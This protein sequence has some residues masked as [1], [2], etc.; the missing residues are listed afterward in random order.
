MTI[1]RR[2]A[3]SA[4]VAVL[5]LVASSCFYGAALQHQADH[6]DTRPWWC[7]ST[8]TGGHHVDP[9]YDGQEKGML[10]W[11]DCLALSAHQA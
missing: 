3:L 7:H 6:P 8:G 5:A 10:S 9:A 1:H 11:D 2:V 4:V